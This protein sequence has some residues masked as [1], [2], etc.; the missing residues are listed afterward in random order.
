[1]KNNHICIFLFVC[2]F[3]SC[4]ENDAK[5]DPAKPSSSKQVEIDE[6]TLPRFSRVNSDISQIKVKNSINESENMNIYTYE[7]LYNGGGISAGDIN[8]DGLPDLFFTINMGINRLYLNKGDMKFEDISTISNIQLGM[9]W[10]TGSTMVD[11]NNDGWLDIYV[12][13]SGKFSSEQRKNALF[14]NNK[15]N[16]FTE[17]AELYG[18]ADQGFST[19]A[20]FFDFD[21]DGD[22]DMYLANHPA[23][24]HLK[25][26]DYLSR[27]KA[28]HDFERDKLYRND[29]GKFVDV[30]KKAG[31]LN[32]SH[33]LGLIT[34]DF[35]GDG[36][37]DIYVSNDYYEQDHFYL[38]NGDGTFKEQAKTALKHMAKSSMGA[39]AGDINNDGAI[40]F[41]T[42]EMMA[43][44]NKRQKNEHGSNES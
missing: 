2:L 29:N 21:N 28:P 24:F 3:A 10:S 23:E 13:R 9:D 12:C 20:S 39:D 37:T 27:K 35:N 8:N 30:S 15:N 19:Q 43:E 26:K 34:T 17:Q 4:I 36:W 41:L 31:I 18:L 14:V 16:T 40:D 42:V 5:N 6:E 33:S 22:L 11:I 7:Y 1:M 44:D 38:N 25:T 32:Y